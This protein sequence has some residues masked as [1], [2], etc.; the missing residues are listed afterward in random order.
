MVHIPDIIAEEA[1]RLGDPIRRALVNLGGG[2]ALLAVPLRK[3]DTFVG[4]FVIY[5][6]EALPF[7]DK[8]IAL[9]QNFAAQAVIAMENARLLGELRRRTDDLQESLEYQTAISDVLKII[10]RSTFD[11]QPVLDTVCETAGRLCGADLGGI[12]TLQGD[13]YRFAA[14]FGQSPD[15]DAVLRQQ[16]HSPGRGSIIGRVLVEGRA[17]QIADL[18]ADPG[19]AVPESV[20]IGKVRSKS[21]RPAYARRPADRRHRSGAPT[22][23]ALHRAA[24][25]TRPHLRRP[26]G[27]RD[28]EYPADQRNS[29]ASAGVARHF[30]QHG[31]RGGHV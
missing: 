25:P 23:R 21:W 8:Q 26:G 9:L 22:S 11:L 12:A 10:S 30:R 19:Y 1:Y 16:S 17:V 28:R 14:T 24:N 6:K 3:D 13:V 15:F 27:D 20:R 7:S 29:P 4:D 2:R 18:A 31:R 5:R